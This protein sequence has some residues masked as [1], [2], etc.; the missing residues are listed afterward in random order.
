M[1]NAARNHRDNVFCML[2]RDR[3]NLLSLYNVMNGTNYG[4]E[5]ELDVVTLDF[6]ICVS[7]RNDSAFVIDS[8]LNLYEQQSTVNPNM[9]LRNLYYISEELKKLVPMSSLYKGRRV[10]IP[11]PRFIVFY[12]GRRAQPPETVLRLSDMYENRSGKPELEL[13]VRQININQGCNDDILQKCESLGGYM[14]FVNKVRRKT[15]AGISA[16]AAVTEA[17]DECIEE[18]V[19]SGFFGRHRNEVIEMGIYEYDA[20]LHDKVLREESWQEGKAEG[21]SEG[22]AEAVLELLEE[23]GTVPDNLRQTVMEQTDLDILKKWLK[24]S[25]GADTIEE[26]EREIGKGEI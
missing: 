7:M 10:Q 1:A 4:N 20:E 26:F 12:N 16:E 22:K 9:P 21:K 19:L 6:A 25:A 3:K 17:V 8:R 13:V 11:A 24:L 5:E 23:L 15:D 18:D 2:Y 14:T